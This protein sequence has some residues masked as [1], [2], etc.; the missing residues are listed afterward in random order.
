MMN[1][2]VN[3][4]KTGINTPIFTDEYSM[5]VTSKVEHI[6]YMFLFSFFSL[7]LIW[8]SWHI[9]QNKTLKTQSG[10]EDISVIKD[11]I[12]KGQN[13]HKNALLLHL[14][15][16]RLGLMAKWPLGL[17]AFYGRNIFNMPCLEFDHEAQMRQKKRNVFS[18]FLPVWSPSRNLWTSLWCLWSRRR[19]G[20]SGTGSTTSRR[21]SPA[22]QHGD[23]H[24]L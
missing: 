19:M 21:R 12:L 5:S 9:I 10:P 14:E 24:W 22:N 7:L 8:Y 3:G 11:L 2:C 18:S 1:N 6:V 13:R 17:L 20:R 4:R 23:D 15:R 16:L